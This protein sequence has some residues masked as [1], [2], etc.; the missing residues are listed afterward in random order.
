VVSRIF[1]LSFVYGNH[2]QVLEKP[3]PSGLYATMEIVSS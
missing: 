1:P 2:L 3:C